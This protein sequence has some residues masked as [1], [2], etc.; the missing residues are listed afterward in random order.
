MQRVAA[1]SQR[2]GGKAHKRA[3]PTRT[4]ADLVC[5]LLALLALLHALRVGRRTLF[6]VLN[7]D[8]LIHPT[9]RGFPNQAPPT[10]S[11]PHQG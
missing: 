3:T 9:L 1:A 11:H 7:N 10:R 4:N 6:I 8:Q 5:P 2:L